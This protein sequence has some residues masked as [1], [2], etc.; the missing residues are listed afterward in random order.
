ME[1]EKTLF[2]VHERMLSST[3]IKHVLTVL[4]S[5]LFLGGKEFNI[6]AYI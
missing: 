1:L 2:R 3:I 6:V 4:V 5:L